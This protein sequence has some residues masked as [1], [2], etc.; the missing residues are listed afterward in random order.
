MSL[1]KNVDRLNTGFSSAIHIFLDLSILTINIFEASLCIYHP[2]F[3][4]V[5]DI[6]SVFVYR[7]IFGGN[8][9]A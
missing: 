5:M 2:N 1:S 7:V 4:I 6:L 9:L 8:L 3:T